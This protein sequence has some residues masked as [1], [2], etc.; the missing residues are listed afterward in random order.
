MSRMVCLALSIANI[1]KK[2]IYTKAKKNNQYHDIFTCYTET[3]DQKRLKKE[4]FAQPTHQL[5][6]V[7]PL[8]CQYLMYLLNRFF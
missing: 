8:I 1:I 2:I 7:C 6:I 4:T 5:K 3:D